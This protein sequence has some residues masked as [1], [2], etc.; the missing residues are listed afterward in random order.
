MPTQHFDFLDDATHAALRL[1]FD[2]VAWMR[3]DRTDFRNAAIC[4]EWD[5]FALFL[6]RAAKRLALFRQPPYEIQVTRMVGGESFAGHTD[7]QYDTDDNDAPIT[8]FV[9]YVGDYATFTGGRL[10]TGGEVVNPV[11]NSL[12]LFDGLATHAI[13]LIQ[14]PDA[15]RL[16]INGCYKVP[17]SEVVIL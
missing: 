4:I 9:Y 3:D 7:A 8:T 6:E 12:V 17:I 2:R 13:E 1:G 10:L 15:Q 16:T 5:G 14:G 11:D